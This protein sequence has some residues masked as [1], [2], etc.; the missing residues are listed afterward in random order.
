MIRPAPPYVTSA[1]VDV[2]ELRFRWDDWLAS[3]VFTYD[4]APIV[5]RA[6][7]LTIRAQVAFG[8]GVYEWVVWRFASVSDDPAPRQVN[9]AAW[10]S[11]ADRR[12]MK[13]YEFDRRKWLGPVRGPLWCAMTFGMTMMLAGDND[14]EGLESGLDYLPR[15]AMHVLPKPEL[16]ESWMSAGLERL[17]RW[18]TAPPA[19]PFEDPFREREEERRGP[20]VAPEALDPDRPYDPAEARTLLARRLGEMHPGDNPFLRVPEEMKPLGFPGTP[21][22]L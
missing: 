21:Y 18:Y 12:Y 1:K 22:R 2:P 20:L 14:A 17:E 7:T 5:A 9:E 11:V 4:A 10:C 6:Q 13:D 19:D 8:I 16:F 3:Q 15:L